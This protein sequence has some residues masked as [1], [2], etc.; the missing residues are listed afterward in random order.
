MNGL[1]KGEVFNR[2]QN[3][4]T[5]KVDNNLTKTTKE[6][7]ISNTFTF[8]NIINLILFIAVI[9]V[10]SY[11]NGLFIVLIIINTLVGIYQEVKTKKVLDTLAILTTA[12]AT[13]LRDG[14]ELKIN[15]ENIVQDELI[16]LRTGDQIP[17][18]AKLLNGQLEVNEALLT[19]EA[20][21]ILKNVGDEV[22]SGSFVT[23]GKAYAVAIRVG[24]DNYSYK[25]TKEAKK[26]QKINSELNNNINKILKLIAIIILPI[27]L[28]LFYK[29][30]FVS[31]F[32]FEE[33]LL[34][35]VAAA[36]G[37]I[38]EGIVLLTTVA[39]ASSVYLLSKKNTLVRELFAIESLAR[40]D[41]LCLDKTGTITEG[42][43]Q[44]EEVVT[45]EE[46]DIEEIIGNILFNS[47][48][49]N[50]TNEALRKK[51]ELRDSYE[52][53]HI[54]PFSSDRKYSG[55]SFKGKGTY[56]LGAKE[57]LLKK[58]SSIIQEC[59]QYAEKGLRVL[60]LA[61]SSKEVS[62]E[63]LPDEIKPVAIILMSDIL[64]P[65]VK[66]TLAY[67]EKEGVQIKV[68]SG[69][70]PRTVSAIAVKAGLTSFKYIDATTLKTKEDIKEAVQEFDIFGR[71][72]PKQKKEMIMA[73]K[74]QNH[75]VGMTGD[76]VNDCLAFKE[77]DIAIAMMSGSEA[78]KSCA[79]LVLLDNNFNAMPSIVNEG[80]RVINNITSS[81]SMYLIKTI[82]SLLIAFITV[83]I[84]QIYPFEPIHLSIIN[85]CCVAIP[86]FFLTYEKNYT[87]IKGSFL[88][89]II[90]N[91]FPIAITI[92]VL[93]TII[94]NLGLSLGESTAMLSTTCVLLAGYNYML[95]LERLYSPMNTYRKIIIYGSEGLYFVCMIIG[96]NLIGLTEINYIGIIVLLAIAHYSNILNNFFA[97]LYIIINKIIL[98][99]INYVKKTFKVK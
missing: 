16:I 63:I 81:S 53:K 76:G 36:L 27:C 23:S 48:D 74:K 68:I 20:D 52:L 3:H 2:I 61:H 99:I 96:K 21:A 26:Q 43:I 57:F 4:Q 1:T 6:I 35:T 33:S 54:I 64:R 71:V 51:Y 67:F 75:V 89:K 94:M 55:A 5:N 83:W 12:K 41:V 87:K 28:S 42:N 8:F 46:A 95:A 97:Y 91:A 32:S 62:N 85:G 29:S 50:A 66:E 38:P 72:T 92:T 60:V 77:A 58:D 73:L 19:G 56:Y 34:K 78:S 70:D 49:S 45:L 88:K 84:G 7:I 18:D 69:D 79:N 31:E 44:V 13:V 39:L 82:F 14:K 9:S 65:N 24:V 59:T 22:L 93:S 98:I 15:L 30:Y 40:V 90:K 10:G 80:R 47:S 11:K 17:T 25:I 86:T 37:M